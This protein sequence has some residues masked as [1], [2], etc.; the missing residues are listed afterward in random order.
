[1]KFI[2]SFM[3]LSVYDEKIESADMGDK[4]DFLR[5]GHNFCVEYTPG[6]GDYLYQSGSCYLLWFLR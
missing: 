6:Y 5:P 2:S 4:T 3:Y 1:M